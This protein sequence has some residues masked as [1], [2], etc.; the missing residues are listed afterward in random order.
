MTLLISNVSLSNV[1]RNVIKQIVCA[2]QLDSVTALVVTA[3]AKTSITAKDKSE[4]TIMASASNC[5]MLL[6]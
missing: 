2:T 3:S 4:A 1:I 5:A 6:C